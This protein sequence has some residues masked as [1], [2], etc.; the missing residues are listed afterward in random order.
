MI[1]RRAVHKR[2][3]K[4]V[5]F[6]DGGL[7]LAVP[8]GSKKINAN[9]PVTSAVGSSSLAMTESALP[10]PARAAALRFAIR[11]ALE[12]NTPRFSGP[13]DH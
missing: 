3:G 12:R 1:C 11:E 6:P 8:V 7:D 5:P 10:A 2:A 13:R 9:E 4:G